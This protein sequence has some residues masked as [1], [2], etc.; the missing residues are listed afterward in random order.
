[1]AFRRSALL[2]AG[3]AGL[4]A[5]GESFA[6]APKPLDGT[7]KGPV[8]QVGREGSYPVVLVFTAKGATSSYPD[9]PCGGVLKRVGTSANFTFYAE[10]I[11]NGRYDTAR[12]KGCLDGTITLRREG[13]KL[14]YSW[15]GVD[16]EDWFT[17]IAVLTR[18]ASVNPGPVTRST[19]TTPAA[20][21]RTAPAGTAPA[22]KPAASKPPTN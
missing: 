5:C 1:M 14:F 22:N 9:S 19:V 17:A 16:G 13:D 2:A 20:T 15:F 6:Q 7:W 3:L 18:E 12:G 8:S 10:E 21:T 4:F 11:T